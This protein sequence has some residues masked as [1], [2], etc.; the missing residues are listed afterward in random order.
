M[1][2]LILRT[3]ISDCTFDQIGRL[4]KVRDAIQVKYPMS[5]KR[6]YSF[7]LSAAT[8]R[9]PISLQAHILSLVIGENAA[10][11]W[12]DILVTREYQLPNSLTRLLK[13][14]GLSAPK[15]VSYAVGQ[16][17]GALSS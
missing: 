12:A 16:P 14:H 7:D 4:E 9:L 15:S 8:D 17:M 5:R 2:Q 10:D 11:A 13:K 6:A 1:V 3:I